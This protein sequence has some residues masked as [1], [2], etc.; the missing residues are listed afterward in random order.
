[1]LI[2]YLVDFLVPLVFLLNLKTT[3]VN[4]LQI[5]KI[6]MWKTLNYLKKTNVNPL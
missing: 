3:N 2:L 6:N 5:S 1:M 4:P